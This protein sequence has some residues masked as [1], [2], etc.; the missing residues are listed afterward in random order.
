MVHEIGRASEVRAA[1]GPWAIG[2]D[3]T[4]PTRPLDLTH[5]GLQT[6]PP[7]LLKPPQ[8]LTTEP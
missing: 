2:A 8:E 4:L 5:P 1:V 7:C 6:A 3:P